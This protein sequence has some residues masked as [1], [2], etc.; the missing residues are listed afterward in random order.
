MATYSHSIGGQTWRFDSLREVLAKASPLRSGDCLAG[1]AATSDAE[2][3]AAQMTLADVPLKQFLLE[4][5]IPYERD[6]VTRLIIDSHDANAFA[7]V[8]HLTV[9]GLRD[10][11]L[12]DHADEAS[13]RALAPGLTPEMAAAVSKIM[14]VQDLILVAQKI[15]VVT[16]FRNTMGLRGHMSTRLQPNHPTD[17]P[18]GIAASTLDGLLYGNGDAMIGIN[19]ATDSMGSICTLLEMLDAVIQRYEIPTQS[20]VLTHVTSSIA[21]IERGAPLD[22]VFQSI[23]GTEAANASFG[24]SLKVLQEGYEAG[25][26]LKRG[27]LGNNLMYFETGQGSALSA[28]AHHDVDQQTCEARAYAVARHFNP[29]LVNTVVGFIGPE[30]LYNGKQIIRAGLE[31][32]FCGKLLGVPM[33]CDICYTN[34]AEADQD[35]MDMLLTLLGTAGIN[36][37][38][39]IPGSDDVMLNYQTTSFHDALYARKVLGLRAAP[40]FEQWLAHM[41]IFQQR[42]GQLRLGNELPSAFRQALAQLS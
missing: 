26:S 10:W 1:V 11:L 12:G 14:R 7:P 20:C 28:N 3:A 34:H 24:I 41:G 40:E 32:H 4:A 33:G 30:Y 39:G 29:F 22:L 36:F 15:R 9:G 27:T 5:V 38:M 6:E 25:L 42:D 37:I 17:D 13:L 8:S 31:D 19:P 21:A 16:R 2:R 23:A 35:D 18:A